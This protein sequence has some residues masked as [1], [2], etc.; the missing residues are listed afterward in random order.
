M[1]RK[2]IRKIGGTGILL[3]L[4]FF[5]VRCDHPKVG[6]L[7][8]RNAIY[9]PDSMIVKSVLDETEDADRIK[10]QIPWQSTSIEGVQGTTPVQYEIRSIES[11]PAYPAAKEQ[12]HMVRKGVVELP[13]NHSVPPGKYVVNIRVFNEGYSYDLDSMYMVIV[14]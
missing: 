9:S 2:I 5:I 12:F 6:Y 4:L 10:Y 3:A 8:V 11:E 14:K 1:E 13:W 7:E